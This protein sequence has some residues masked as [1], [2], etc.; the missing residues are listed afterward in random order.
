M[1]RL[2]SCEERCQEISDQISDETGL[3]TSRTYKTPSV[4]FMVS[5]SLRGHILP[6]T[7]LD[8]T[9]L[10]S[11]RLGS[12][13]RVCCTTRQDT[14][15]AN[16][17]SRTTRPRH[18]ITTHICPET[19]HLGNTRQLCPP[20]VAHRALPTER[21]STHI[22]RDLILLA[23]QHLLAIS[24]TPTCKADRVGDHSHRAEAG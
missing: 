11:A 5:G 24:D 19:L 20:S 14:L 18:R 16:S 7:I 13:H 6:R 8:S 1:F 9:R 4:L 3:R 15:S 12:T 21:W 22:S 2:A 10:D 17:S 23:L